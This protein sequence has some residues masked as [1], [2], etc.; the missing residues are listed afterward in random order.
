MIE[1]KRVD[2]NNPPEGKHLFIFDDIIFEGWT[3][4]R[5]DDDGYPMWQANEG[6]EC[7]DVRWYAEINLPE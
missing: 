4:D 7:Y 2:K 1:W 5:V 3:F 6:P